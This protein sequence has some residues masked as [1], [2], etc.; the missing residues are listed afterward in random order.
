MSRIEIVVRLTNK[1]IGSFSRLTQ[2]QA[3]GTLAIET[4]ELVAGRSV[5]LAFPFRSTSISLNRFIFRFMSSLPF[6]KRIDR[7]L[8]SS[9]ALL[10]FLGVIAVVYT[11]AYLGYPVLPGNS[12]YPEGWWGWWDQS[13]Y[14]KCT[15][16]LAKGVLNKDTYLYPLGYSLVAAPFYLWAPKHAF[17]LPNLVFVI[18]SVW[19][20]YGI[21]RR[22]VRPTEAFILI[23]AFLVFYRGMLLDTLVVPWNTIP[24][25][26]LAYMILYLTAFRRPSLREVYLAS[27]CL[28]LMYPFKMPEFVCLFPCVLIAVASLRDKTRVVRASCVLAIAVGVAVVVMLSVNFSVF[29]SFRTRYELIQQGIGVLGYPMLWKVYF[30]FVS[31]GPVFRESHQML[32]SHAPWLLLLLPGLIYLLWRHKSE[33]WGIILS[34][35]LC[36]GIY[37]NYN[38]LNSGNLYRYYLIHYFT[39]ALPLLALITFVGIREAWRR[40]GLRW[41]FCSIP[42]LLALVCFITLREK[43]IASFSSDDA[44]VI[45]IPEKADRSIDWVLLRGASSFPARIT[46]NGRDWQYAADFMTKVRPDG[47][48]I[49]PSKR[50][51]GRAF[52]ITPQNPREIQRIEFGELVW[53]IRWSPKW[54]LYQWTRRFTRMRVSVLGKVAGIDLAGLSGFPDGAPDEV[55]SVELPGWVASHIKDWQI[56]LEDNRGHWFTSPTVQ[57]DLLIKTSNPPNVQGARDTGAIRLCFPDNGNFDTASVVHIR[58]FDAQGQLVIE[59]AIA[60]P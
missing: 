21:A 42:F 48:A 7:M 17:F 51:A 26:F 57:G 29:G 31:G 44:S 55:I 56:E 60:R 32:L 37:V 12:I 54:L 20:F 10:S 52:E 30:L 43:T 2:K 25:H 59:S 27:I 41:S 3:D 6:L 1:W 5:W 58:G 18:G 11:L 50:V 53:T 36:F 46:T 35:A 4:D 13:Q 24:T 28:A 34:I 40:R 8:D 47:V 16:G 19:A 23:I 38:E 49:L 15:A 33:A 9:S 14:L 22:L 39:W 45:N